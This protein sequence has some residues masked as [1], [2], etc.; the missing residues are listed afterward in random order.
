MNRGLDTRMRR[1]ERNA[2]DPVQAA[3]DALSEEDIN[4]AKAA[5][6][7]RINGTQNG[8]ADLDAAGLPQTVQRLFQAWA[9]RSR[10]PGSSSLAPKLASPRSLG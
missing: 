9:E 6:Q 3:L 5:I 7:A 1:L 4:V 10:L 8:T 2:P